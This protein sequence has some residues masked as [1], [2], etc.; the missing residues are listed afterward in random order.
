MTA[1]LAAPA[2]AAALL[3]TAPAA[4][5]DRI[6]RLDP[7]T[8]TVYSGQHSL[9][10]VRAPDG[11]TVTPIIAPAAG[12]GNVGPVG[13]TKTGNY[14]TGLVVFPGGLDEFSVFYQYFVWGPRRALASMGISPASRPTSASRSTVRPEQSLPSTQLLWVTARRR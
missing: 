1:R 13:Y 6:Y 8:W 2:I 12:R 9:P 4:A 5:A 10:A 14:Q 3:S 7:S 11:S